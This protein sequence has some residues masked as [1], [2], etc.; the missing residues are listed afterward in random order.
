[1]EEVCDR[2]EADMRVR[3][4]IDALPGQQLRRPGLIEEDK[5]PD[6]LPFRRGQGTSDLETAKVA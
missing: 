2:T 5:G 3:S 1:M 4:N 6:H